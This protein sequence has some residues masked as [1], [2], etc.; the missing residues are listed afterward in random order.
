MALTKAHNRMIQNAALNVRD[1]GAVGDGVA[2]DTVA[3]QAAINA[4]SS[5]N[6]AVYI[7]AGLY[8]V[9]PASPLIVKDG[10]TVYG[11]GRAV[12]QLVAKPVAG[13]IIKRQRNIGSG[14]Q[15]INDVCIRDIGIILRHPAVADP[16]NYYQIAIDYHSITRSFIER[17][18]IGNYPSGSTEGVLTNPASQADARQ[19]YGIVIASTSA[20]D[21]SYAGGE[22][23]TIRDVMIAG[24][25][26]GI[27][28][29]DPTFYSP[30]YSSAAYVTLVDRCEVQIAE[31]GIAQW[32]QFGAGCTFANNTLQAIDNMR[33]SSATTYSLY[34]SGYE[35]LA[36]GG[37][38]E[39]PNVDYELFLASNSR[40]N[41]ILTWL[42]D[43]GV[44]Q[45]DGIG[46][47]IEKM[48]GSTN[49]Y[50][51]TVN[52][53]D[54]R[55]RLLRAWAKFY[56]DGAAIVISDR[57]NI[58]TIA[59]LGVGDYRVDFSSGVMA[60]ANYAVSI[61]GAV[62]A[63][64]HEGYGYIRT[65]GGQ[66]SSNCRIITYDARGGAPADFTTVTVN[67]FAN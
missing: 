59:R 15:Y 55:S 60:D 47:V 17:V 35:H 67:F 10:L 31:V 34:L 65:S 21:P 66:T 25:R 52:G 42:S 58:A 5:G 1:F 28:I 8:L 44:F 9:D 4:V 11:D 54:D 27:T 18:Y 57:Y 41:R 39:S 2:D 22:V 6:G 63:S 7:P 20:S 3:I 14:N 24:V 38:N 53:K 51:V 26:Y 37:Y 56:W 45:D 30:G 64:G 19:G 32:N 23:N 33:G 50:T 62:N 40:R 12:T 29:D 36:Y 46:N 13:T 43:D 48:D 61:A 49:K 16:S